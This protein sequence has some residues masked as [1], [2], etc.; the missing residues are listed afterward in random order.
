MDVKHCICHGEMVLPVE[1]AIGVK[2]ASAW[3]RIE[4]LWKKLM[5]NGDRGKGELIFV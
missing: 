4:G 2:K 5:E 3:K 1:S